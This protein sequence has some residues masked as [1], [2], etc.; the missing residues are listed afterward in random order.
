MSIENA[1]KKYKQNNIPFLQSRVE[2]D[3]HRK[4]KT[5]HMRKR[6]TVNANGQK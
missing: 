2:K 6:H 5:A 3:D 4:K 1:R